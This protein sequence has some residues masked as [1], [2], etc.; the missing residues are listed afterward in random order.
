[1]VFLVV[2]AIIAQSQSELESVMER[3]KSK[4]D[5]VMLDIMDGVF[6]P[7][8]SLDFEFIPPEGFEYEAH[9]LTVDPIERLKTIAG[10][11]EIA[12]LHVETLTDI[13]KAIE[14]VREFGL[15]VTLA[16]NPETDVSVIEPFLSEIDGVLV[17]TVNPGKYGGKYIPEALKK[18]SSIRRKNPKI[19]IEV[20]GG[21]NPKNSRAARQAGATI[22]AS[23][24]YIIK[25]DDVEHAIKALSI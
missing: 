20:D 8:R 13:K 10:M 5:R 23:G 16:L 9:L 15:K 6:V 4:V 14:L 22:I 25:S 17:M 3:F 18:V 2:P 19:T 7:N 1:M 24:S 12:I 21:M 11:V